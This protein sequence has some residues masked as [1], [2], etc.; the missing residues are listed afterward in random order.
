MYEI[1]FGAYLVGVRCDFGASKIAK[2]INESESLDEF[3]YKPW[4]LSFIFS[5]GHG[6]HNIKY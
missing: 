5:I 2:L 3:R 4:T 1:F 6:V